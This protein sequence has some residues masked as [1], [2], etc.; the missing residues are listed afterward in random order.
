MLDGTYRFVGEMVTMTAENSI[1]HRAQTV[2]T[3]V[4]ESNFL[5]KLGDRGSPQM[6]TV[7]IDRVANRRHLKCETLVTNRRAEIASNKFRISK[8]R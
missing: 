3:V 1:S 4:E 6:G 5:I 7:L 8:T 2:G